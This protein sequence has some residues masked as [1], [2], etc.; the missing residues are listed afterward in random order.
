MRYVVL[1]CV[2]LAVLAAGGAWAQ[3]AGS[4]WL[5]VY[6][7]DLTKE[8]A[9]ALGWEA[10]RGAKVVKP[11]PGSPA[12]AAGL[13]PGDVLVTLDGV[14]IEN[15]K[16][17]IEAVSK[18]AAGTE[19][20][21]AISR[22]GREK[23]LAVKL[24]ARPAQFAAKPKAAEDAPIPMLDTGGHMAMIKD[25][26]FTPDG[27][28]LVSASDDKVIRVWDVATGKTVRTLHGE[29][30]A[31]DAG[32]IYAM[33]LSPDGK[34]LAVGGCLQN[35]RRSQRSPSASTISPRAAWWRCSRGMR[36]SSMASPFRPMG[37]V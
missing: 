11:M 2:A 36:T 8:E 31:G 12:E 18:K 22:A 30:A 24:G 32:K 13:Q 3:E 1:V 29:A 33:A 20:R 7:E 19:V 21:L 26:A 27:R 28:Q 14:E 15:V 9:D 17:F 37:G 6:V 34:W 5:G 10:P 16:A 23:R 4:G 25:I 35:P